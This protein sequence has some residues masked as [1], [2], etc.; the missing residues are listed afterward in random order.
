[1]VIEAPS[2]IVVVPFAE[3][4]RSEEEREASSGQFPTILQ[5]C[6]VH[7]IML[8]QMNTYINALVRILGSID[9]CTYD[10]R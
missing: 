9:S 4:Q 8:P 5:N 7:C 10:K 1:M 6:I 3:L 2:A